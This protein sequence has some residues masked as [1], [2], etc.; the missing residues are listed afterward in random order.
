[1]RKG[2]R[3]HNFIVLNFTV[4]CKVLYSAWWWLQMPKH[5]AVFTC[6]IKMCTDCN[7][8]SILYVLLL[9]RYMTSCLKRSTNSSFL[10]VKRSRRIGDIPPLCSTEVKHK[11]SC[12]P[13]PTSVSITACSGVTFTFT[14]ISSHRR[15]CTFKHNHSVTRR[16]LPR[17]NPNL[18]MEE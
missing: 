5:V 11:Y 1:V 7:P 10:G 4:S 17:P 2:S 18:N 16:P 3:P 9:E 8:A 14:F 12:T 13:N 15:W 6:T